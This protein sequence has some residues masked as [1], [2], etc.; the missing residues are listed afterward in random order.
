VNAEGRTEF[1]GRDEFARRATAWLEK[2]E[3]ESGGSAGVDAA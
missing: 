2:R 3:R 1:V